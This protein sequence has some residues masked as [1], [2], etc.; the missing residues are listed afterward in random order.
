MESH[1]ENEIVLFV[2]NKTSESE[3]LIE[4]MR[5]CLKTT[6]KFDVI[7]SEQADVP[8][9]RTSKGRFVDKEGINLYVEMFCEQ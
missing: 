8:M 1:I 3:H 5:E 4:L 7:E 2:S 9:I 6:D